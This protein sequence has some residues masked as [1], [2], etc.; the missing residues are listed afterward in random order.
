MHKQILTSVAAGLAICGQVHAQTLDADV[1]HDRLMGMWLGE[2]VG[3]Y[4]GRPV[5]G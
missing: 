2:I 1:Y 4:A 5:E 3:N